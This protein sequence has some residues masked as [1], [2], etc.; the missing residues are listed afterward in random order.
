V[1]PPQRNIAAYYDAFY[2][3]GDFPHYSPAVTRSVL[4][5]LS[6]KI[7]LPPGARVLDVGCAT[8]YYSAAFS[9][10]GYDVTGIDISTTAIETARQRHPQLRFMQGDAL[11]SLPEGTRFDL[12]FAFGF[13]PANTEDLEQVRET[14]RQLA[15]HLRPGGTLAFLG[16]S[17]LTGSVTPSSDWH[18]HRWKDITGF[19]PATL[20]VTGGPWLTHFRCLH[21]LP[22]SFSL[23]APLTHLL[24]WLPLPFE[25]RIVLLLRATPSA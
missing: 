24:R 23:S 7:G 19:A 6:R 17:R 16:G 12:V 10:L 22:L 14:L 21:L 13:S 11:A 2:R 20:R 5:A 15:G 9:E 25:R 3:D 1:N 8:G 4:A 18:N